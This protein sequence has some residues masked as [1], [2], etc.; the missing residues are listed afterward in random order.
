MDN[1]GGNHKWNGYQPTT[2]Q[3]TMIVTRIW[4][5]NF[6]CV[7]T[8]IHTTPYNS[9]SYYKYPSVETQNEMCTHPPLISEMIKKTKNILTNNLYFNPFRL[10]FT[11]FDEEAGH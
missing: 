10:F 5:V 3:T 9:M 7:E 6:S 8:E 11:L 1:F 2:Q 4:M